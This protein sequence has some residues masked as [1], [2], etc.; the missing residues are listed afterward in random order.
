M[1]GL[2]DRHIWGATPCIKDRPRRRL[3]LAKLGPLA[4]KIRTDSWRGLSFFNRRYAGAAVRGARNSGRC[5]IRAVR[6][7]NQI[8]FGGRRQI[9][10]AINEHQIRRKAAIL[11]GNSGSGVGSCAGRERDLASH[12][13]CPLVATKIRPGAVYCADGRCQS[14][15]GAFADCRENGRTAKSSK[16]ARVSRNSGPLAGM[17]RAVF[18]FC[19]NGLFPKIPRTTRE[20][21]AAWVLLSAYLSSPPPQRLPLGME[22]RGGLVRGRM[23]VSKV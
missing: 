1:D 8:S 22:E 2:P 3:D 6:L 17:S 20:H 9:Q 21:E 18:A 10:G 4:G 11:F 14:V 7:G 15:G 23:L 12:D 5:G 16:E 13:L 19:S